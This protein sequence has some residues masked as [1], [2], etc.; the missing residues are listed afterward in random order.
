[1]VCSDIPILREIGQDECRYFDLQ[2]DATAHLVHRLSEILATPD[3]QRP[4]GGR[5]ARDTAARAYLQF[6]R[7]LQ[8]LSC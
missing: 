2:G 1:M 3:A 4:V 8:D 7:A 5:F 6:Y